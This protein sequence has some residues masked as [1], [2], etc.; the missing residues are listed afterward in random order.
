VHIEDRDHRRDLP[1]L[2]RHLAADADPHGFS[3][4]T[5][6]GEIWTPSDHG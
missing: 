4:S 5:E 1:K 2:V 6:Q 3:L